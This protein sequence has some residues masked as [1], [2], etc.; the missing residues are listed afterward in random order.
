MSTD[1]TMRTAN[2]SR[3]RPVTAVVVLAVVQA[4]L[5]MAIGALLVA[6]RTDASVAASLEIDRSGVFPTGVAL[7]V[8]GVLPAVLAVGLAR[9][10]EL[11]RSVTAAVMTLQLA[12]SVFAFVAL[13]DLRPAG[14]TTLI[15]PVTV[16]WLL[17]GVDRSQEF[18]AR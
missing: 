14:V 4:G 11:A 8:L 15:V 5:L 7:I 9:G 13:Q 17:Y 10:S 18:F 6:S 3:P 2:R 1:A 16:L 12:P